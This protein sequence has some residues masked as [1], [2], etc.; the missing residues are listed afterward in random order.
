MG[1]LIG[2]VIVCAIIA[3]WV[4]RGLQMKKLAHDGVP[5]AGKVIE[6]SRRSTQP[7]KMSTGYLRYEFYAGN[8]L[9]YE[10]KIAVGET[11]YANH[12]EGDAIDVVY[13]PD[14]PE[15]SAAKY[16]VNLSREALKLPPL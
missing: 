7:G 4:H 8:G 12:E 16:M 15:I 2:L 10:R 14:K 5:A 6:K 3:V 1:F 11:I 9:R 13:V